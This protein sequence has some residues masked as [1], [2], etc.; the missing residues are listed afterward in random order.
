MIGLSTV[1]RILDDPAC[2]G[3]QVVI[4]ASCF[5]DDADADVS[6][7][8]TTSKAGAHF[9]PF[10]STTASQA[11]DASFTKDTFAHFTRLAG[12]G[13]GTG[14]IDASAGARRCVGVD[15]LEKHVRA[16]EERWPGYAEVVT[17]FRELDRPEL[18]ELPE[19]V[20]F[21]ASYDTYTLDPHVYALWLLRGLRADRRVA[22]RRERV[23]SVHDV[24]NAYTD[25]SVVVNAS[26]TGF[27]KEDP[28]VYLVRGQT[29]LVRAP[30]CGL[31]TLAGKTVTH[32]LKNGD[33]SFVIPRTDTLIVLGGTKVVMDSVDRPDLLSRDEDVNESATIIKNART[34]FPQLFDSNGNIDVVRAIVG[35][36]PARHGGARV[37]GERVYRKD[38]GAGCV[39]VHAYGFGGSGIEMSWGAAGRAASIV[40]ANINT[41]A[42]K[43]NTMTKTSSKL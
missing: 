28:N 2:A 30:P 23:D 41:K 6:V 37:E 34:R 24:V 5:P 36:R 15:C 22:F 12:A 25:A 40:V 32:Q 7:E 1:R 18:A 10:P 39:V 4:V 35:Y 27:T 3:E 42:N 13:T 14:T 31:G 11:A 16:Y 9:R 21:A 43:V 19:G 20:V 8:Y 17:R 33:W 38:S 29:L 26:G